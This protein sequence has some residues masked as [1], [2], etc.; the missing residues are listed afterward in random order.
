MAET[1]QQVIAGVYALLRRPSQQKLAARDVQERVGD[2]LKGY[3]QDLNLEGRQSRVAVSD[4]QL[5]R[6]A[7]GSYAFAIGEA[8]EFEP[9][10][11][12]SG[13]AAASGVEWSQTQ[14]VP[15]DVFDRHYAGRGEVAA[16][17]FGADGGAR[18]RMNLSPERVASL[19]WRVSYRLPL[20]AVVQMGERPPLPTSFLPMLKFAAAVEC[21]FLVNDTSEEWSAWWRAT[22]PLYVRRAEKEEE[23]WQKY[24]ERSLEPE[25]VPL[26]SFNSFR[27]GTRS[28]RPR[29]YLEI[30]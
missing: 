17:Y 23:R 30:E 9:V 5:D 25:L 14:L 19:R 29:A 26:P 3:V 15:F 22:A 8:E 4:V 16:L 10:S 21:G 28:R 24:L 13:S 18:L 7:D 27:T 1:M 2:L 6:Q 12:E 11:L 20:L